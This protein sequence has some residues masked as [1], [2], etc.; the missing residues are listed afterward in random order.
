MRGEKQLRTIL[1]LPG[2]K[3]PHHNKQVIAKVTDGIQTKFFTFGPHVSRKHIYEIMPMVWQ[4]WR[5]DERRKKRG[6]GA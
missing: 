2:K 6:N 3:F 1:C 5:F 4:D